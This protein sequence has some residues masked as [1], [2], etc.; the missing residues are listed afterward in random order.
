M[1]EQ[2]N[3]LANHNA[4]SCL[5][6]IQGG[7]VHIQQ[8]YSRA[9]IGVL[10]NILN[11]TPS[12]LVS[13]WLLTIASMTVGD[14]PDRVNRE[15][16]IPPQAFKSE[17]DIKRFPD[18]AGRLGL[19][20]NGLAGGCIVEDFDN[21]GYLDLMVSR[22]GLRDQLRFFRNNAD[23]SFTERTFEAGLVAE[24]GGLNLIQTDYNNDGYADAMVLRGGWLAGQGHYPKSLL[25]NN[26]DGTFSDVTEEAGLLSFRPSQTAVWFD[27]N[28][29]GWL[30]VFMGNESVEADVNPCELYRNNRDGTFTE[31]A[32]EV[33]VAN[34]GYVKA[35][36]SADFNQD[37]W[38]DLYLSRS[39][40]PNVLYRNDGPSGS[41]KSLK[42]PWR[43]TDVTESAGVAEPVFSFPAFFFDQDNDGWPDLYV[44]G[45]NLGQ[46]GVG[47]I[48]A[49][50]LGQPTKAAKPR[51]YRNNRDGT[52]KDVTQSARLNR[53]LHSMGSNFGDLDNDG[54]LDMY[55]GTGDP[56]LRTVI[57]NRMLRNAD[58]KFF[59]DVTTSGGFGN[60]QKGHA[61]AF[62]DLDNDGDQ[63]IYEVLGGAVEG[64]VYSN[65]LFENPG[66]G[67]HWITLK[68][69][70]KRSNRAAIGARIRVVVK[71]GWWR[72]R[73]IYKT[74]GSG[75]SFGASP[76]R[77]EIGLGAA[78]T[79]QRVEILW[80]AT[81][82]TQILKGLEVDRFYQ[83][84]EDGPAAAAWPV[85][86]L[87]L[88]G[89]TNS[90]H[91]H[92]H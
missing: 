32:K 12:D 79:V 89:N 78:T 19:D 75:G 13:R 72:E 91:H 1:A 38:P 68:L 50:Y 16:V 33:G 53:I 37:G 70:G 86:S 7:G 66:H 31:C 77:Q 9:A 58:G 20:L 82:K 52:F 69:E 28:N 10:T 27:Y 83:I 47:E 74:V 42:A 2:T 45:F 51:L 63:D 39:A 21:D 29:D 57:P 24:V 35:V 65:V 5:L 36:V 41:D 4:D 62:G 56:I 23:G 59:Q 26:G 73:S 80:P 87:R 49:E 25:R 88:T 48:A 64:D 76:F 6:P 90:E 60:L 55:L 34:V 22:W 46:A 84:Q 44:S 18:I 11:A 92:H 40:Q 71:E 30:D 3:C 85:R 54:F 43:F 67:N 15:W 8:Q 61:I 14:Y 17:Y 81:G